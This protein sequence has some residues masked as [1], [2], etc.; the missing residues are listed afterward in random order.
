MNWSIKRPFVPVALS[1]IAGVLVADWISFP[2][3]ALCVLT[4]DVALLALIWARHRSLL[5]LPLIFLA[6][7]INL[8]LHTALLSPH[9][10]RAIM[11]TRSEFLTLRGALSETPYHRIYDQNS[12]P[13]HRSIAQINVHA[14]KLKNESWRP[15]CGVVAVSTAGILPDKFHA[16]QEV[17]VAGVLQ[18]PRAPVAEGLFDY[19]TFL[20]RAGIFYQLK[21]DTLDDWKIVPPITVPTVSERFL[22]WAKNILSLGMPAEDEP[23]RLLWTM[24]LG[25]KSALNGAVAEPFMRSGTMHIFA[26]SGLHIALIAGILVALLR[27]MRVPRSVCGLIVIPLIWFYTGVT[28]WQAS[29][30]R[31]TVMM[32]VVIAG[33]SLRRPSDLLNSLAVAGGIILL[34]EPQQIFQASFQLSFFVVLSL[35]LFSPVLENIRRRWLQADLLLPDELRPRWQRWLRPPV[36]WMTAGFT[37]SLAAWLGSI[38]LIVFYFHLFTPVSLLANVIVVPLSSLA[39]TSNLASLLVGGWWPGLAELFNHSAWFWMLLMVRVS[40]WSANLPGGCFQIGTPSALAFVI[41]YTALVAVMSGW[42]KQPRWR[43]WVCAGLGVMCLA[44]GYQWQQERQV[45]RLSILPLSGGSAIYFDAPGKV[46]DTLV[47][48]GNESSVEFI[49]KPFLQARGANQIPRLVLTHGDVRSVGGAQYLSKSFSVQQTVSSSVRFRSP[50][51]RQIVADLERQPD[52]WRQVNRGDMFG[53]WTV[54]HPQ[55]KDN[56]PQA[57]SAALVL[58]GTFHGVRVLLLSDLGRPGQEALLARGGDLRADIVMAGLPVEGEPLCEGLLDAIRPR[59]VVITDSELPATRRA[60]V[61]LRERLRQRKISMFYTEKSGAV[62][63]ELRPD[64]TAVRAM[65]G[66]WLEF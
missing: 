7:A 13:V 19:R 17:E 24:T 14:I 33:W 41:Y 31:S 35:A 26:I 53:P 6:G 5:L 48:C 34:W 59:V 47:D 49:V 15:V 27:V 60:S 28:G 18:P 56:F 45:T 12:E 66:T 46:D 64:G 16:G 65:D 39:L 2:V 61:A 20:R 29:A 50:I 10:L 58:A 22:G 36:F 9:D 42:L 43:R 11:E 25:W 57:D 4:L 62:T 30:I 44:W 37:T 40:E 38:P 55:A 32:S 23:L 21:V 1:Y 3:A 51:Y 63:V 8:T 52:R 54:L